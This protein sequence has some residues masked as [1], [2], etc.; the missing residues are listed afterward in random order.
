MAPV[1]RDQ[2][3]RLPTPARSSP[4][5]RATRRPSPA[6]VEG[7]GVSEAV[8]AALVGAVGVVLTALIARSDRRADSRYDALSRQ[9]VQVEGRVG[10]ID[11]EVRFGRQEITQRIDRLYELL[12]EQAAGE[13]VSFDDEPSGPVEAEP[14]AGAAPRRR[15]PP[16][17]SPIRRPEGE[18]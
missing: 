1:E 14:P 18:S 2:R 6:P 8:V 17:R 11:A 7:V 15:R 3:H 10:T 12:V 4:S 9:L 16:R 13:W 5:G